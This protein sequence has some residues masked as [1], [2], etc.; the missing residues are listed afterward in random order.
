M[1]KLSSDILPI[2]NEIRKTRNKKTYEELSNEYAAFKEAF[3]TLFDIV[4]NINETVEEVKLL[5]YLVN[6]L[7]LVENDE[8]TR[9]DN[10]VAVGN[11]IAHKFLYGKNGMPI[12]SKEMLEKHKESERVKYEAD[13]LNP[14]KDTSGS[15]VK[16]KDV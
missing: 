9:F 11:E 10:N 13:L 7:A 15:E 4:S 6:K 2:I 16:W 14:N 5:N 12:P 3:R 1:S 8:K